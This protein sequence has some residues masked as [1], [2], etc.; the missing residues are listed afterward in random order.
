MLTETVHFRPEAD[1]S[2]GPPWLGDLEWLSRVGQGW[3]SAH[4]R[5][6]GMGGRADPQCEWRQLAGRS[7]GTIDASQAEPAMIRPGSAP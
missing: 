5:S 3:L 1:I 6:I 4:T 7:G 2:M